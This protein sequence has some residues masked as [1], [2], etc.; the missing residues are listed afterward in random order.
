MGGPMRLTTD[1]LHCGGSRPV[2]VG[3]CP[4]AIGEGAGDPGGQGHHL[5]QENCLEIHCLCRV[6]IFSLFTEL[7]ASQLFFAKVTSLL[8]IRHCN[9]HYSL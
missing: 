6:E 1:L 3:S 7:T 8:K 5:D 9:F 4:G 2:G